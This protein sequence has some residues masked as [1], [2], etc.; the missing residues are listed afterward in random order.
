MKRWYP[1]RSKV[2]NARA[3]AVDFTPRE[4]FVTLYRLSTAVMATPNELPGPS[5]LCIEAT[6]ALTLRTVGN[7]SSSNG[8]S[9]T[10]PRRPRKRPRNPDSWKRA[11]AKAKRNRGEQYTSPTTGKVVEARKTGPD[12][13]C[14]RRCFDRV[15]EEERASIITAFY[16]LSN[17]DLQDAHLFGLIQANSVERRRPR[18]V[19]GVSR[20]SSYTYSVSGL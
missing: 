14:R 3:C 10:T 15:T 20:Q 7:G 16:Q 5:G 11:V 13:L 18:N 1:G 8:S 19:G 17:K 6:V 12:C 4:R 2:T 9:D